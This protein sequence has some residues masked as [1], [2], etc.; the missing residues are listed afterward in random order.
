MGIWKYDAE[1]DAPTGTRRLVD[2]T[3]PGGHLTA[4]VEGLAIRYG[5]GGSGL[6]IASSQGDSSFVIYER[7]GDNPVLAKLKVGH[8]GVDGCDETDGIDVTAR[9]LPPDFPSGLFVCHDGRDDDERDRMTNF[10]FVPL[11]RLEPAL[12]TA[13]R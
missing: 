5:P 6:L 13:R 4:D 3:G 10:K 1:P 12:Q 2:S 9:S 7:S 8:N 11:D